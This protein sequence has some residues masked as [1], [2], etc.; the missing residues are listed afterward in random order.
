M[1]LYVSYHWR[2]KLRLK[3]KKLP[4]GGK[5]ACERIKLFNKFSFKQII[6]LISCLKA[7]FQKRHRYT[8]VLQGFRRHRTWWACE[9][10]IYCTFWLEKRFFW[11]WVTEMFKNKEAYR[12]SPSLFPPF[13][14][15][16]CFFRLSV[17][18]ESLAFKTY[19]W[20]DFLHIVKVN[21]ENKIIIGLIT[22]LESHVNWNSI[23]SIVKTTMAKRNK[24]KFN[25]K[26]LKM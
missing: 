19:F 14:L 26:G 13:S 25:K 9:S 23:H 3:K 12:L 2:T 8:V 5:N 11:M 10:L 6:F 20:L 16:T 22:G 17:L 7:E 21:F 1:W 15:L 4:D 24:Y 18:S